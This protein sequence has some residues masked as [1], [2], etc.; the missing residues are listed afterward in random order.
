MNTT[1]NRDYDVLVV[2]AGP[3]GLLLAGDVAAAGL[4]VA[5]LEKRTEESKLTRAFAVHARTLEELDARGVA[6]ELL[7]TGA[8]LS[9][10]SIFGAVHVDMS[11]LPSRFPELLITPQYQ[12]ERVL[13]RRALGAGATLLRG[14]EVTDLRQD[15]DAVEVDA[16]VDGETVTLRAAYAVGSDGV[17]STVRRLLGVD[18]PGESAISSVMLADVRLDTPPEDVL[19]VGA[20]K[21]GFAFMAPYG[22]GWYRVIAWDHAEQ[23]PDSAPVD[24]EA[25]SR[26]VTSVLDRDHGLHDPRWTSRFHSDERQATRYRVG[27]VFLAGDAAHCHSPAGGQGM[28]TGLQDAANLGWKLVAAVRGWA[29][30]GLLDSY[31]A[32]RHPVGAQVLRT[33][34]GLLRLSIGQTAPLRLARGLAKALGSHLAPLARRGGMEVSGISVS[35]RDQAPAGSHRLVGDRAADIDLAD[36]GSDADGKAPTRLY[37]ALR[38]GRFVLVGPEGTSSGEGL[39]A[40][41]SDRV[42][43]ATAPSLTSEW[44]LVRPDGY[45]AWAAENPSTEQAH[46]GL[47]AWLGN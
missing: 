3:T 10:L 37:E 40:D 17:R 30:P 20:N 4:R 9:D 27:R 24:F 36:P 39:P 15:A 14:A 25:M 7:Q 44:V 13:L 35:Y 18:Y 19:A 12:T 21:Q 46:T 42:V 16:L 29:A 28:N 6:D 11:T 22:D 31:Q 43:T 34:G 33:S 32:E 47:G 38:E 5:L 45:V 41:W 26:L 1:Q 23:L 2:G 8:R